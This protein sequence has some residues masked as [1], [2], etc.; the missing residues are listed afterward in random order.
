MRASLI[1]PAN[2]GVVQVTEIRD[3]N[4]KFSIF[5]SRFRTASHAGLKIEN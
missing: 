5:N 1:H 3:F 2:S 4:F